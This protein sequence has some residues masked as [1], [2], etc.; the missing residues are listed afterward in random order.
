MN[1]RV[2]EEIELK[3]NK[4]NCNRECVYLV[5]RVWYGEEWRGMERKE[6]VGE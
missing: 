4:G 1:R 6:V 3:I 5:E 2:N